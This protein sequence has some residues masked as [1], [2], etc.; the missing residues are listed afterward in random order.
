VK[1][2][3]SRIKEIRK[4]IKKNGKS[5]SQEEFGLTLG[6][7][8]DVIANLERAVNPVA[9][10]EQMIKLLC[11]EHNVNE[12]W[13]RTGE[14]EMFLPADP[15]AE[16]AEFVGTVLSDAR[17]SFRK[18]LIRALADLPEEGWEAIEAF[19]RKLA[20]KNED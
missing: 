7:S 5:L 20:E 16:I 11:R 10:T 4:S 1:Y 9:P 3:N 17:P 13:L 2:L 8:R 19:A 14:G 12:Q 15:D 6:V 18:K